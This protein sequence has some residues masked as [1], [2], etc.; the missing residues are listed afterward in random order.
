MDKPIDEMTEQEL[1]LEIA[2]IKGY[3]FWDTLDKLGPWAKLFTWGK[4][5]EVY[6]A[7]GI[8]MY[9]VENPVDPTWGDDDPNWPGDIG[10]A[11]ELFYEMEPHGMIRLSNGDGDSRDIDFLPYMGDRAVQRKS[12]NVSAKTYELAICKAYLLWKR[13]Q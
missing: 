9:E 1:R 3:T 7:G 5:R 2:K 8:P 10:A 11:M 12:I 6:Y 4:P 13:S